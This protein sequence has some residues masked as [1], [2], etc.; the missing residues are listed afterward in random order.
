MCVGMYA[1]PLPVQRAVRDG[2]EREGCGMNPYPLYLIVC[3][4]GVCKF[5]TE[6][7]LLLDAALNTLNELLFARL[8]F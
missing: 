2:K 4:D 1:S 5:G 3:G 7:F 8:P 6:T